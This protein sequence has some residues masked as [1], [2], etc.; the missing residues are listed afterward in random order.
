MKYSEAEKKV[1]EL[2]AVLA[3][4]E[5]ED[6][7]RLMDYFFEQIRATEGTER[8]ELVYRALESIYL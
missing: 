6:F 4:M 3:S 2:V 8:L 1:S 7:L 5:N